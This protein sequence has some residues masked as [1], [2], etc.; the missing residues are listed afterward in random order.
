MI[1]YLTL[2]QIIQI[3]DAALEF[4]GSPGIRDRHA[5]ESVVEMPRMAMYGNDLYPHIYDKAATYLYHIVQNH[6]FV[7]GNKRTG[8][9][10][11]QLFLRIND[12]ID[13]I[14]DEVYEEFVVDLAQGLMSKEDVSNFFQHYIEQNEISDVASL[15][16]RNHEDI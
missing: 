11:A 2:E 5:L 4:G 10:S 12:V 16:K 8:A 6:P 9:A 1:F 15:I 13:N 7:D 3:H 14:P